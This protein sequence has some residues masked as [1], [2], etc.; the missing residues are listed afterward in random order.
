MTKVFKSI[1]LIL[2]CLFFGSFLGLI[3]TVM[4]YVF[5]SHPNTCMLP[6]VGRVIA[7]IVTNLL[8]IFVST[9][10]YLDHKSYKH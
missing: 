9:M 8:I 6:F 10:S 5:F 1:E 4:F 3:A 7:Y 2:S